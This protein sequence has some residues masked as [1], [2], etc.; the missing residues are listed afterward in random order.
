M[1][2][3]L[4]SL[5]IVLLAIVGAYIAWAA[6]AI[7]KVDIENCKEGDII[8]QISK[9][10]Q[11]TAIAWATKSTWTHCGIII[12]KPDGKYVLEAIG[13]VSLTPLDKW[14]KRG[15]GGN[16]TISRKIHEPMKVKY[17]KY[18]GMPYDLE[19]KFNNGKMYCS[20]LVYEIYKEQFNLELAKP[21][22]IKE[23]NTIGLKALMK[24][25]KMNMEQLAI[26]PED[27]R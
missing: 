6:D 8:F 7:T 3:V 2:K 4:I 26:S 5:S 21:K 22:K 13:K 9:S 16:Y 24:R 10:N 23:Y 25:R 1:K 17:A 12:E 14:L 20:E 11:S 27:I 19:F 15:L 18:L